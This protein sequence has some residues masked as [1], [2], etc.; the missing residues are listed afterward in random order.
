M[1]DY[2]L[3]L[4]DFRE[5]TDCFGYVKSLGIR[6]DT[7]LGDW[8]V[9]K[10]Y[11]HFVKIIQEKGLPT[12]VSFDHDLADEHY[13]GE[14][15]SPESWEE[16]YSSEYREMTGCDCAKWLIEHCRTNSLTL[17]HCYCYSMNPIGRENINN[18]IKRQLLC[19]A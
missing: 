13:Q 3:F 11:A 7:Y 18:L 17:P 1:S 5:P 4:D 19:Q 16:Y 10:N 9:A 15:S 14:I 2:K 6:P 8:I 12:V